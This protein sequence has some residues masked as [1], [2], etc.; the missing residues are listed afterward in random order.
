MAVFTPTAGDDIFTV[1]L[2]TDTFAPKPPGVDGGMDT[3]N[4]KLN[5]HNNL[6]TIETVLGYKIKNLNLTGTLNLNGT[7]NTLANKI[8]GN[9]SKNTLVGAQGNDTLN[10]G[11]GDD[12]LFGNAGNDLLLGGS[13][14]DTL[15]GGAGIDALFGG[16]GKDLLKGDSGNDYLNGGLG[17]DTLTGGANND[18]FAFS[19]SSEG[20]DTITDFTLGS[21]KIAIKS[22]GFNNIATINL[23]LGTAASSGLADEFFY[24]SGTGGL[25]YDADGAVGGSIQ[26]A[27]LTSKPA[28]LTTAN[29]LVF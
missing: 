11:A 24:D 28:S 17:N 19:S 27:T 2:A 8:T 18:L 10:G 16:S 6:S 20:I 21:D 13:G 1:T 26:L 23:T 7:G 15:N 3:I 9:A 5:L 29:F 12:T 25:Y 4:T 22:V 14:N